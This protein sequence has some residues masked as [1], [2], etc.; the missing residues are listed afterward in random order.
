P[1]HVLATVRQRPLTA[2]VL[3]RGPTRGQVTA[4]RRGIAGMQAIDNST[5][6]IHARRRSYVVMVVAL[7]AAC[8]APRNPHASG[9]SAAAVVRGFPTFPRATWDGDI[10]TQEADG[11]LTW[12]VSWTAPS[13]ESEVRR[14]FLRTVGGFGWLISGA[15][16]P[17]ELTL[18][19]A[20][21]QLRGYLR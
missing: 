1:A 3:G 9:L 17:D 18:R 15:S 14:F 16:S 20:D 5:D 8:G 10:T 13:A 2:T 6:R 4:R 19:H 7:L 11:Q 12:V 21:L